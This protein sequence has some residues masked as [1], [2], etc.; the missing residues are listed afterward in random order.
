MSRKKIILISILLA[1]IIIGLLIF[2]KTMKLSEI[3][4]GSHKADIV[5]SAADLV[6]QFEASESDANKAFLD[7]IVLVTGTVEGLTEDQTVITV[8]LKNQGDIS[9]VLCSF[10]K[11][12]VKKEE[13]IAGKQIKVKGI[14]TG[15]LMDVVLTKC[16]L[17][18]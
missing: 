13:F 17:V 16:S 9:G 5:V 11:N 15:Y 6:A 12:T 7:K 8:S 14:C 3:S 1:A 18:E 4:V 10:D 2:I